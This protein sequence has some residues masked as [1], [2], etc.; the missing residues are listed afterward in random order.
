MTRAGAAAETRKQIDGADLSAMTTADRLYVSDVLH[1]T[2][3]EVDEAG[4]EAAADRLSSEP[5]PVASVT[6]VSGRMAGVDRATIRASCPSCGEVE[7]PGDEFTIRCCIETMQ[8]TYRFRCPGCSSW[9][10]KDADPRV[11][12]LLLRGGARV[13]RWELPSEIAERPDSSAPPINADDL[14]AFRQALEQLPTA[15]PDTN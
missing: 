5:R 10:V 9:A 1:T 15:A 8:S 11:I 2:F 3:I 4:T 13:E 6:A 7:L 14:T 12:S